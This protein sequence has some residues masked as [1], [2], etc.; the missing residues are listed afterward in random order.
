MNT[1]QIA[2]IWQTIGHNTIG[3]DSQW[4]W[5]FAQFVTVLIGLVFIYH[6]LKL[7]RM[8]NSLSS[9][10]EFENSWK[11]QEMMAAR[12]EICG[13]VCDPK[14]GG[15]QSAERISCF[16]ETLGLY[17]SRKVFD[18]AIIWELYS[19]YVEHYW[20]IL[21]PKI[22]EMRKGDPTIYTAFEA[23]HDKM[24]VFSEKRGAPSHEKSPE[25]LLEFAKS[26]LEK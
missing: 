15:T 25:M 18:R 14:G 3:T 6:Q 17:L 19:Y 2:T 21:K 4:F 1:N 16:F 13:N 10:A 9:L 26:E 12:Q 22:T 8:A 23:L 7:Q 20:P 24:R 5:S 11:S